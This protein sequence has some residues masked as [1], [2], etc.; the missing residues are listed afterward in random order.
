MPSTGSKTIS[1]TMARIEFGMLCGSHSGTRM[2]P[3]GVVIVAN[4]WARMV[5]A[6]G[7]LPPK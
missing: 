6:F 4:A 1:A 7:S 5:A 3:F 2:R